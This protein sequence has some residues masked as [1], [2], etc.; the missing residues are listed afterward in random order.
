MPT[1]QG[2]AAFFIDQKPDSV[3]KADLGLG[4]GLLLIKFMKD[5]YVNQNADLLICREK[6]RIS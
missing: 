6:P 4:Y 3:S 1:R 2:I 5:E